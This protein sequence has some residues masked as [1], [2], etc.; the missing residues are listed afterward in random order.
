MLRIESG[1]LK[2]KL[3][4]TVPDPRT[5][6][7]SAILRRSLI[8]MVEFEGKVCADVCCGSGSVGFEML[9]NGAKEVVFVD[10][11]N[12]AIST[13]KENAKNLGLDD[14]IKIYKEDV[15][16]FLESYGSVFDI[17]Y[18]DPP[19]ELGL[20]NDIVQRVHN[21]MHET[22]IFIL[23]CSKREIPDENIL[24]FIRVFKIKEY[25]DSFLVFLR[26]CDIIK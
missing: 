9:S 23:Q 17:I 16:R 7:T 11:S 4:K 6:Y 25:G 15:R 8:N 3:I 18:S 24:K 14:K 13:V 12:K 10:V 21:V 20:V 1:E 22:S 5:R 2:G 26:K 19:Y